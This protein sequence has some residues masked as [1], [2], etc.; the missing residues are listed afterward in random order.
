[1]LPI[2]PQNGRAR[3]HAAHRAL[4]FAGLCLAGIVAAQEPTPDHQGP[5]IK[6]KVQQV[7]VPVV[8]TD[9]RG[10]FVTGFK[11]SDFQVFEDGVEQ[12]LVA[13][14]TEANG[15]SALFPSEPEPKP[16]TGGS[17]ALSPQV[18]GEPVARTYLIVLDTLFSSFGDFH[19]A[20]EALSKLFKDEDGAG[21]QYALVAL[22]R[23]TSVIQNLTRD[24]EAI[25]AAVESKDLTRTIT[26]SEHSNLAQQESE[27]LDILEH[28]PSSSK[29]K[30]GPDEPCPAA[31]SFANEAARERDELSRNLITELRSLTE[32]LSRMPGR[33]SIILASDGFSLQPGRELF[34]LVAAYT[35][36]QSVL[37]HNKSSYL[38]SELGPVVQLATARNVTFYTLDARGLY[39]LPAG[40]YDASQRVAINPKLAATVLPAMESAKSTSAW[41]Q[42]DA[43]SYLAA[44]TG[45]VFYHDK[46]DLLKG[47]RQAFADGREYYVLAYD[48]SNRAADGRYRTIR[49]RVKNR[50]LV[51]RAKRGYWAPMFSPASAPTS[52][53]ATAHAEPP[54]A[55]P[56][57]VPPPL[58]PPPIA[59]AL[60]VE[61]STLEAPSAPSLVDIPTDELIREFPQLKQ[62]DPAGNQDILSSILQKVGANVANLF[63]RFP[64]ITC[65]EAV[66]EQRLAGPGR[67]QDQI[68]QEF[69]YLAVASDD[70]E[71]TGFKEYRTDA[72][73]KA[74]Q[75]RGLGSGYLITEGFVSTPLYFHPRYQSDSRFR[76]L[77]EEL[78]G[79]RRTEVVAF[80][81][82]PTAR[83]RELFSIS[84]GQQFALA[85]GIAWIDSTDHQI[86][87]MLKEITSPAL[88]IGLESQ[89]TQ[90]T[91]GEVRFKGDSPALWLPREVKVETRLSGVVYRNTHFYSEFKQFAVRTVEKEGGP[92][93]R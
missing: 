33:R 12:K 72:K 59:V 81:Q 3:P 1:M 83:V 7:L 29:P 8:V 65:R 37:L 58:P 34:E 21:S 45:G 10:H 54:A 41:E 55:S 82:K 50:S 70:K 2:V 17:I 28:C 23:P 77:G 26:S 49:V 36:D 16:A 90:V 60:P 91:F 62:L 87:W 32:Q 24:P 79:K 74:V 88:E 14:S 5:T 68:Y 15:A 66:T 67:E 27:L 75:Q 73:G 30:A 40:G 86:V 46:N 89:I 47:L 53:T 57:P 9:R 31:E 85:Q 63:D 42:Q 20:R 35:N 80:A 69:R 18:G 11:A 38:L 4:A 6:V 93:L 51:V 84:G 44:A 43:M 25:L 22:G 61:S 48:P 13:L 78:V 56:T 52:T 39:T 71:K 64:N 19:Q 92:V 76:Y